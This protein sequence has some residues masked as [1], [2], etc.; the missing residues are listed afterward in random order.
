MNCFFCISLLVHDGWSVVPDACFVRQTVSWLT[1]GS[2]YQM[3][4]SHYVTQQFYENVNNCVVEIVASDSV[5]RMT[6]DP[7]NIMSLSFNLISNPD[8]VER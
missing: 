7:K 2:V 3:N 6:A 8:L 1:D 5:Q 4:G